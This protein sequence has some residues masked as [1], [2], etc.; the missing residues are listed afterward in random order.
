MSPF[1]P[2]LI[3]CFK[4]QWYGHG[5]NSCSGMPV[6]SC[7]AM[8]DHSH[9]ACQ[10]GPS[11]INSKGSQPPFSMDCPTWQQWH[12]IQEFW[13]WHDISSGSKH[14]QLL[15][16]H[17][18]WVVMLL[19]WGLF[20]FGSLVILNTLLGIWPAEKFRFL[21]KYSFHLTFLQVCWHPLK[22]QK[23]EAVCFSEM[24]D[25]YISLHHIV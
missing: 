20:A 23:L 24:Y 22:F 8:A 15:H 4:C 16:A 18:L 25:F 10:L 2:S 17:A 3:L 14:M 5:Q 13:V 11:Y 1:V 19:L 6:C 7:C 21:K 9:D 12:Q